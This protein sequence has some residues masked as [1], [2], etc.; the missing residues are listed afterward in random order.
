MPKKSSSVEVAEDN[1]QDTLLIESS[2]SKAKITIGQKMLEEGFSMAQIGRELR[3]TEDQKAYLT[4]N[5]DTSPKPE[6]ETF[7]AWKERQ[8][9]EYTRE[10]VEQGREELRRLKETES[11]ASTERLSVLKDASA[12]G[13]L[14]LKKGQ[15]GAES[16]KLT[17]NFRNLANAQKPTLGT[18][19][20][21]VVDLQP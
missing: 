13:Y 20:G 12:V 9:Q 19:I 11:L 4:E 7:E 15:E 17:I 8:A 14:W 21:S 1:A 5:P 10:V 16:G 2:W 6:L 3:L 18:G